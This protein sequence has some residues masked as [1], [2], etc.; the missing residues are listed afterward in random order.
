MTIGRVQQCTCRTNLNAVATLR[1][2][3][4][5]AVGSDYRIR[6]AAAGFDRVF[7][8]PLIANA[9]AAFA[10]DATLRIVRNHRRKVSLRIIV[11]LFSEPL[12]QAAPIESHL[13]QFTLATA[14]ADGTIK[15]MICQ[16]K[17]QH[18]TL[19]LFN[20]IAL[21]GDNHSVSADDGAGRLQLRHLLDTHQ[22]HPAGS[23]QREIGV[24][25]EGGNVESLVAADVDQPRALWH[26]EFFLVDGDFD[27]FCGH[28]CYEARS[29]RT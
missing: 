13:L 22:A 2:V 18:R 27:Y 3:K 8:H 10:E 21:G 1:T 12:F 15:R 29:S 24:V 25:T 17:L 7:A 16:Q 6:T 26:F 11:F 19:R 4:P 9:S 20:L 5:A 28:S 23:L 14:I